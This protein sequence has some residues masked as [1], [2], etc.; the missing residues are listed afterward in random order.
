MA[1]KIKEK[2]LA[3]LEDFG[4][5]TAQLSGVSSTLAQLSDNSILTDGISIDSFTSAFD[6]CLDVID[7]V[8]SMVYWPK[9]SEIV[10]FDWTDLGSNLIRIDL[11][12]LSNN[13]FQTDEWKQGHDQ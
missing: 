12:K 10:E 5:S 3:S 1:L 6:P 11:H 9:V 13:F 2:K 8:R 4:I 7:T